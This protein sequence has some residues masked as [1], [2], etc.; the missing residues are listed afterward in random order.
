M[1]DIGVTKSVSTMGFLFL[2]ILCMCNLQKGLT[3]QPLY[4]KLMQNY[5]NNKIVHTGNRLTP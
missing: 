3:L 4:I 5:N 1:P 2:K